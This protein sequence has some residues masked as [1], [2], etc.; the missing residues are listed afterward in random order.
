M[1]HISRHFPGHFITLICGRRY[2]ID[3]I[4]V[5]AKM[6]Q[7]DIFDNREFE[8]STLYGYEDACLRLVVRSC[9]MAMS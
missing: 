1:S 4:H 6:Y 9:T 5:I 2:E 8:I 3:E 7:E